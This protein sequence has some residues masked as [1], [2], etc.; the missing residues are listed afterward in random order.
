MRFGGTAC[1][2]TFV[3]IIDKSAAALGAAALRAAMTL[4]LTKTQVEAE[5][6]VKGV[7]QDNVKAAMN[8]VESREMR[9]H[10]PQRR[11]DRFA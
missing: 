5:Y 3:T 11:L 1:E 2:E 6:A 7:I 10:D 4:R 9:P 8:M